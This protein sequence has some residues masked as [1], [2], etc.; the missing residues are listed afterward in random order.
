MSNNADYS[1]LC[2][3]EVLLNIL[4]NSKEEPLITY[5]ELARNLPF[6]IN[7]RNLDQPLGI[8]SDICKDYQMPLISII[9]VNQDT[10][11]PG[12]GYFKYYFP[13]TKENEWDRIFIEQFKRVKEYTNWKTLTEILGLKVK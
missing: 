5:G 8:L 6:D 13:G 3:A 10:Y 12:N 1:V 4:I 9:V 11:R 2:I 7:P